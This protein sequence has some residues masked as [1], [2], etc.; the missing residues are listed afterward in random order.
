MHLVDHRFGEEPARDAGLVRDEDDAEAGA[1]ERANRVDRPGIERQA[2][3]AIEIA[4][5]LDDRA[6]AIEEDGAGLT[7]G[8]II[9]L[10]AAATAATEMP[11]MHG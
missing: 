4:D 11:R 2:L 9:R 5:L 3:D 1:V 6:V 10:A 7:G 8:H